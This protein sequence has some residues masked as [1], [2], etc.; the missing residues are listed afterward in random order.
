M[1]IF[2]VN[3]LIYAFRP[4]MEHHERCRKLLDTARQSNGPFG[5]SE[6]ALSGFVRIVTSKRVFRKPDATVEALAFCDALLTSPNANR[7]RP[8][9]RHWSIFSDLCKQVEARDK[10]VAD[11]YHAALAIEHGA[12]WVS[13]DRDFSK[14]PGLRWKNPL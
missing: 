13:T 10:L 4:D 6:L 1:Q 14:F 12:E 3:V 5:V 8:G 9:D 7:V 2:D 11:A